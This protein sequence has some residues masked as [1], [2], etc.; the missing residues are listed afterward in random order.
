[1]ENQN[2]KISL[3]KKLSLG[4]KIGYGMGSVADSIIVDF[5]G[6]FF[7]F[8]LTDLVG[9]N[10]AIA[11]SI[12]LIAVLWDAVSDPVIGMLSDKSTCKYGK[13][14]PFI[15]AS[16]LPIFITTILMFKVANFSGKWTVVYYIIVAILYWTSYTTFNIPYM[17]LGASLTNDPT[18]RTSLSSIRQSLAFIG[19]IGA[20]ALPG[21]MIGKLI[22]GGSAPDKAYSTVAIILGTISAVTIFITWV[23][24]KGKELE[25]SEDSSNLSFGKTISNLFK[26]KSYIILIIVAVLIFI[27]FTMFSANQMYIVT[28]IL[29]FG[30]IQAGQVF[31]VIA[32]SGVLI[33]LIISKITEKIDKKNVFIALTVITSIVMIAVKFTGVTSLGQ[34]TIFCVITNFGISGFLVLIYNFLYDVIDVIEFKYNNRCSGVVLSYYSFIVKFGK[35]LAMQ[36][37]GIILAVGGY[38]AEVAVQSAQAKASIL[39]A[40]TIYPGILF[41]LAGILMIFYPITINKIKALNIANENRRNGQKYDTTGFTDL[42]K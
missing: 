27:G 29:G 13:R 1:M 37:I 12:G 5:V 20:I 11:G 40:S 39:S 41:L 21:M 22:E 2:A 26:V 38:N 9:I 3:G 4:T 17:A 25:Y 42:I 31:L 30:E 33:S 10:P 6:A 14:R 24:T 23:T 36:L 28:A 8:F 15:L 35:A 19:L 7:L 34:Y 18:E 32:I 16:I